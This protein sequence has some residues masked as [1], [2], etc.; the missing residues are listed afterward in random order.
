MNAEAFAVRGVLVVTP[1]LR[2]PRLFRKDLSTRNTTSTVITRN[3]TPSPAAIIQRCWVLFPIS[4]ATNIVLVFRLLPL[5]LCASDRLGACHHSA[6]ASLRYL[7]PSFF[8]LS[9]PLNLYLSTPTILTR[10]SL[11]RSATALLPPARPTPLPEPHY[12]ATSPA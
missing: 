4:S 9:F 10:Q 2:P 3:T 5:F 1:S 12:L 8:S 6:G 7:F 11:A